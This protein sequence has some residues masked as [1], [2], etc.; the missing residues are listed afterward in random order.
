MK[1]WITGILLMILAG[2]VFL[3]GA[4]TYKVEAFTEEESAWIMQARE[5][6]YELIETKD[7]LA[8]VYLTDEYALKTQADVDS[9][10]VVNVNSGQS[11]WIQDVEISPEYESWVQVKLTKD[12]VT[13][14]G[15]MQRKYIACAD[16][17][18]LQWENMYGMNMSANLFAIDLEAAYE[19]IEQFPES[20]HAGLTALKEAH[21]NWIF[22][23]MDTGL[24]W[25]TVV[26]EELFGGRSLV[27]NY[28]GGHLQEGDFGSGWGYATE[29]ALEYYLDP[30]NGLT[31]KEIFQFEQLTFNSSY[32]EDCQPALQRFLD[33]TFMKGNVPQTVMTYAHVFF[34]IGKEM[35]ISPFHLASR[36]YQEQGKGTS[37]LISGTYPGYEGYYNYFNFGAS[38]KTNQEVIENGLKYAKQQGWNSPYN[39]LHFGAKK[40]GLNYISKGQDTLY[41][42]KFDV[43]ASSNGLYYHQYM[44]NIMAPSSEAKNIYKLYNEVGALDNVFVFKIPVYNNMPE[45][46]SPMPTSSDRVILDVPAGYAGTTIYIDGVA[47]GAEMKNGYLVA[48]GAGLEAKNAVMYQYDSAGIPVGMSVW[49]L[50]LAGNYYKPILVEELKD[51]M[52]YHGFSIRITGRAGIRFKTGI[53]TSLRDTLL[54]DG[55]AGYKLKEYGTLVMNDA[56]RA[57]YPMVL[58]G[59]KVATGKAYGY[60]E[61][62]ELIDNIYETINDRHRF[63]SVLV[64]MPA[65]QYKTDFAFRGYMVLT[66]G[67]K[68]MVV[69]GPIMTRS[70]Y[71][72]AEQALSLNLYEENSEAWLFLKQLITD[73]D[74]PSEPIEVPATE[75]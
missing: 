12:D 40:L 10:T 34:A 74:T 19:D 31:E 37:P 44:Q 66:K 55:A 22:V 27:S 30:R 65:E 36:V 21:P 26:K 67:E 1:K 3:S 9:E 28:A 15:Y 60:D 54:G 53:S 20:Y 70:I 51:L 14:T 62:N 16:E 25:D 64:G 23:K 49:E 63:T 6:L 69:Y 43:D 42:Q 11:V 75:S 39:A 52:S 46:A 45:V 41:L 56:N 73:G 32:H 38:G 8:A 2:G 59:E 7:I 35:N 71:K 4:N 17:L 48:K 68:E 57:T 5:A 13:Y 61:N 29:E 50:E 24:E 72:L 33:N 18:F 58:G 47:Y